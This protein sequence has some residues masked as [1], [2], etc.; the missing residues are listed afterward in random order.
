MLDAQRNAVANIRPGIVTF[1]L[2]VAWLDW[3][4]AVGLTIETTSRPGLL[5]VALP[6]LAPQAM[7]ILGI[8]WGSNVARMSYFIWNIFSAV[9]SLSGGD[10]GD[11]GGMLSEIGG[12]FSYAFMIA[13]LGS[14]LMP[15][16]NQWFL[17]QRVKNKVA[18]PAAKLARA[19]RNIKLAV[20]WSLILPTSLVIAIPLHTPVLAVIISCSVA[21]CV[22]IVQLARQGL[23]IYQLGSLV[24]A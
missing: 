18:T 23:K 24:T 17:D 12:Y 16:A 15:K 21:C 20:C 13:I 22:G 8:G 14:L 7:L 1:A 4:M 6:T 10:V 5:G 2:V 3:L 9:L 19:K 11:S